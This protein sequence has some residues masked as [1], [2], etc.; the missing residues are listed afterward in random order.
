MSELIE[1]FRVNAENTS[2]AKVEKM[3]NKVHRLRS[4]IS[5]GSDLYASEPSPIARIARLISKSA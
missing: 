1:Q 5:A 2:D 3:V 4:L